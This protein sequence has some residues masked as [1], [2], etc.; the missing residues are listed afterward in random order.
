ML[1]SEARVMA[2]LR[3]GTRTTRELLA[4]SEVAEST[5]RRAL[6]N[7]SWRG[8]VAPAR[9]HSGSWALSG[10]GRAWAETARGRALL[11]VPARAR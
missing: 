10:R 4:V 6:R 3:S 7:L 5:A 2:A 11:D 8:L 9:D 1:E